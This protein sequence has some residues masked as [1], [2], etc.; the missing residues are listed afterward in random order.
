MKKSAIIVI[1]LAITLLLSGCKSDPIELSFRITWG[2]ASGRGEAINLIVSNFNNSQKDI[3]VTMIGGNEDNDEL[4]E[5]LNADN[6]PEIIVLPYRYIQSFGA[7]GYLMSLSAHFEVESLNHSEQV[8]ELARV[9]DTLYGFPWI[10]HSMSLI[11]NNDILTDAGISPDSIDSFDALALAVEQV[12]RETDKAGIALVGSDH[13][14]LS[15]MTTMFIHSFGGT[16]IN[17]S[18]S[19]ISINSASSAEALNYYINILG[20]HAQDGWE[21]HNGVDVMSS[22]RNQEVAF[23]IQGPWGITDIWKAGNPFEVGS[24]SFTRLGGASEIGPM[25]LSI[26][27]NISE[28][29]SEAALEFIKYLNTIEALEQIMD[30]EYSPKHQAYYPFRVPIRTD[31]VDSDYFNTYPEF[32]EFIYG[33]DNPSINTPTPEWTTIHSTYYQ[34]GL[35]DVILG[36]MTIQDFLS[37]IE[38]EGN[39]IMQ[40][41]T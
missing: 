1:V 19:E 35:H 14:D 33:F 25:M 26:P 18:K 13:H 34:P 30:G 15:W 12:E 32:K 11:Y 3:I 4:T 5:L 21:N 28:D 6:A 8:L 23:E 29:K 38:T 36:E 16:L 20:S 22:F 41:K 17:D 39:I 37:M 2:E 7:E 31:M 40:N 27:N 9:A 10:G 24:I